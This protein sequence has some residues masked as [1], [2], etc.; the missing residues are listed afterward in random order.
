MEESKVLKSIVL[1]NLKDSVDE[2]LKKYKPD[3]TID[4]SKVKIEY[5]RN[6]KFGDYSTA[7]L[8]ENKSGLG[9][10]IENSKLLL[11]IL[12]SKNKFFSE[13]T[14]S[15]PGFIN[16]RVSHDSLKEYIKT[17]I[18]DEKNRFPIIEKKEK[19]IFEFV[20]ANPT[21]PL[22]IVSAR[23]AATG[24]SICNLLQAIGHEVYREF[25]VND[26]GNQVFLLGVSCLIRLR[27]MKGEEVKYQEKDD[28]SE[29][30]SLI[31][32]NTL[33]YEAYRGDYIKD[34]S[35]K[36]YSNPEWKEKIDSLL[37]QKDYLTLSELLSL[38]AIK[39]NL[40]SQKRD[41]ENFSVKFDNYFS[42]RTL[43]ESNK[44]LKV[45]DKLKAA[46]DINEED[47][48]YIFLSTK[49][50]DDKDRVV[51]REDGRPTYLL[52]DIAYH[53]DKMERGFDK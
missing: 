3:V 26:Y 34:I 29:I 30:N 49:Y 36:I 51:V 18:I 15:N 40:S 17:S 23:A 24:D 5:S 33:P 50:G 31:E 12:N 10:P 9:N 1:Q 53:N 13:I 2:F 4:P 19:I 43:H 44:V 46:N 37:S 21:G 8:L 41:L 32:S 25:Y 20:S 47:G 42:E 38:E 16:F 11:E 27:E 6:E 48:K 14:F 45:L 28:T 39:T 22:N 52:A 35:E 7:F